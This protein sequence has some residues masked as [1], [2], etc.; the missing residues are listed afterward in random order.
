VDADIG[1]DSQR[2]GD[3]SRNKDFLCNTVHTHKYD[4]S[5][6]TTIARV[7][8][9]GANGQQVTRDINIR[10]L[11]FDLDLPPTTRKVYDEIT[12]LVRTLDVS[13]PQINELKTLLLDL[14]KNLSDTTETAA[15]IPTIRTFLSEQKPAL[16]QEQKDKL[17]LILKSLDTEATKAAD[18]AGVLEKAKAEIL[19]LTPT[20]L[21]SKI[22]EHFNAIEKADGNKDK[23][24]TSLQELLKEL[25]AAVAPSSDVVGPNQIDPVDFE[26]VRGNICEIAGFYEIQTTNCVQETVDEEPA[27][28]PNTVAQTTTS[29]L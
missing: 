17:D 4:P 24:K 20:S 14:R 7:Y 28:T 23:I 19:L 8:Y 3:P 25:G 10:F 27:P 9:I 29:T 22:E 1:E 11:D 21:K 13:Q 12:A 26:S 15:V 6:E 18:G 16:T 5:F 2:D